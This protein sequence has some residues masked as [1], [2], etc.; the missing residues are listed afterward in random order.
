MAL[1][2]SSPSEANR[3]IE[4]AHT[5]TT[6]SKTPIV[7]NSR[8]WVPMNTAAA[9]AT[10]AFLYKGELSTVPKATGQ[11]WAMGDLLYWDNSAGKFTTTSSG[12][13]KAGYAL[14]AAASGDTTGTMFFDS[15]AS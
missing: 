10:N 8:V 4:F 9:N 5:S 2:V 13:T 11:A 12:N 15:F 3:V 14:A 7:N 6:T 1:Y